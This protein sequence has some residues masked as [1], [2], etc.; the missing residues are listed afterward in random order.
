[1]SNPR[2]RLKIVGDVLGGK[3]FVF[4]PDTPIT[5]GRTDDNTVVLD[6][7]SVSRRHA[8]IERDGGYFILTDLGSHNGTRVG[9][10]LVTRHYLKP[11]DVVWFG[12]VGV[13]FSLVDDQDAGLPAVVP[14]EGEQG[15]TLERP[16]T[17][18]EV[19]GSAAVSYTHL[20]LPTN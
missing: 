8:K 18:Q 9:Q 17:L 16:L 12:Q 10:Q 20:T 2:L 3:E 5:I 14:P 15:T 1:M 19:F 13:E 6:H 7:K 11:G 4:D